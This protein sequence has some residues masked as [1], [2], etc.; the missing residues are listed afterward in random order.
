MTKN[1]TNAQWSSMEAY[2]GNLNWIGL[3]SDLFILCKSEQTTIMDSFQF[4]MKFRDSWSRVEQSQNV[5]LYYNL[6]FL[7][8]NGHCK[9]HMNQLKHL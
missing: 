1:T 2:K 8:L 4:G 6:S 9:T 3:E 7:L 5:Q